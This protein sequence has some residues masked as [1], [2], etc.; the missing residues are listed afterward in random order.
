VTRRRTKWGP[1][2]VAALAVACGGRS[3][4]RERDADRGD[5]VGAPVFD[6]DGASI[7]LRW[8][9]YNRGSYGWSR[10]RSALAGEEL[11]LVESLRVV[12]NT[13]TCADDDPEARI[14]VTDRSG[15][16]HEYHANAG[17]GSCRE[18]YVLVDYESVLTLLDRLDCYLSGAYDGSSLEYAARLTPDDG[19]QHGIHSSLADATD[20][21][22]FVV[23]VP[24]AGRYR[25]AIADCIEPTLTLELRDPS[26][27]IVLGSA[28]SV[29]GSCPSLSVELPDA[30]AYALK[31]LKTAPDTSG[32]YYLSVETEAAP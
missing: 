29:D 32:N 28:E 24:D 31:V 14:R 12:E 23:E 30:G 20:E 7:E 16:E 15:R 8:F 9:S 2:V 17:Q 21:W 25:F 11:A 22:W 10:S 13:G 18:A 6:D 1:V 3:D 19:C 27:E 4:G 26:A 5:V